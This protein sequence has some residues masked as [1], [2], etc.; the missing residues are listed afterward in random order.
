MLPWEKLCFD[1]GSAPNTDRF[2][3]LPAS[4]LDELSVGKD[5]ARDDIGE[6]VVTIK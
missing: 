6:G 2:S 3:P 1:V 4:V 5:A